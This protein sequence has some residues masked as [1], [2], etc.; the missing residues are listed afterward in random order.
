M[1][2][3]ILA[4][5]L[6]VIGSISA[7]IAFAKAPKYNLKSKEIYGGYEEVGSSG[8]TEYK[9]G[10]PCIGAEVLKI[11]GKAVL[12]LSTYDVS[13]PLNA[14]NGRIIFKKEGSDFA[15]CD[16]PGCFDLLGVSG[17]IYPKKQG[18]KYIPAVKVYLYKEYP[19][20]DEEDSPSGEV[21]ETERFIKR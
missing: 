12:H 2:S 13:I 3:Y 18:N 14:S 1:K 5:S 16:D 21:T 20:P 7:S 19:Y 8:C 10:L 15:Q 6:M 11:N 17:V 4:L 9:T